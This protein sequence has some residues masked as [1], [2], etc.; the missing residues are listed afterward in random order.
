MAGSVVATVSEVLAATALVTAAL[1]EALLATHKGAFGAAWSIASPGPQRLAGCLL[2]ESRSQFGEDLML[3]PSLVEAS[4]GAPGSFVEI[5]ALDGVTFS[6]TIALE[7]C[8]GWRGLLIE[9]NP[10]N[11]KE[12]ARSGRL[13]R[14]VHSAVCSGVGEVEFT[15]NGGAVAG[16]L[17]TLAAS[18]REE[19]GAKQGK[20]SVMV[21]CE[22]LDSIM[23]EAGF[24][25]ATFFSLDVEG[26]EELVLANVRPQR[27]SV[28]T[29]EIDGRDKKRDGRIFGAMAAAGLR[30]ASSLWLPFGGNFLSRALPIPAELRVAHDGSRRGPWGPG[31]THFKAN[32]G[33]LVRQVVDAGHPNDRRRGRSPHRRRTTPR[34][35]SAARGGGW[36]QLTRSS[37]SW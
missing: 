26:A 29:I 1:A 12:L 5:G 11:Y 9:G 22:S 15:E 19:W 34:R 3:L 21:K 18:H 8:L 10:A 14:M 37:R 32:L 33:R 25:N 31:G 13:S 17:S 2:R 27:F 28:V 16:Q 30:N 4:G 24:G 35:T 36:R 7:R 20:T 6:N 23:D